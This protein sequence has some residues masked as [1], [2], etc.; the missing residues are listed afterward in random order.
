MLKINAVKQ[1]GNFGSINKFDLEHL[2]NIIGT[3]RKL[4]FVLIMLRV[5]KS[6]YKK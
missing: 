1:M 4:V 3:N 5:G 6:K 2:Y